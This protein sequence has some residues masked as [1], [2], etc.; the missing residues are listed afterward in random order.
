MNSIDH[1]LQSQFLGLLI[2]KDKQAG[3]IYSAFI[4][5]VGGAI[6]TFGMGAL[7]TLKQL[8][9]TILKFVTGCAVS[10][11]NLLAAI[12][13]NPSNCIQNWGWTAALNHLH[14]A[15]INLTATFSVPVVTLFASAERARE[16]FYS[17]DCIQIEL[18]KQHSQSLSA[19]KQELATKTEELK[20]KVGELS[21]L[22]TDKQSLTNTISTLT[23]S[24]EALKNPKP[25]ETPVNQLQSPQIQQEPITHDSCHMSLK[26]KD[27]EINRLKDEVKNANA[28]ASLKQ[29]SMDELARQVELLKVN[30]EDKNIAC[31][32]LQVEIN[33]LN[34]DISTL[35][36]Q[37]TQS[38]PSTNNSNPP[39]SNSQNIDSK[40]PIK[41]GTPPPP[42]PKPKNQEN[43]QK[44]AKSL[45]QNVKD[46][47]PPPPIPQKETGLSLAD[48]INAKM[49][50]LKKAND[51]PPINDQKVSLLSSLVAAL[52][53]HRSAVN[54]DQPDEA[55]SDDDWKDTVAIPPADTKGADIKAD[56][57]SN[58]LDAEEKIAEKSKIWEDA[59]LEIVST[60][61]DDVV[62]ILYQ[63][64]NKIGSKEKETDKTFFVE[65]LKVIIENNQELNA[66][67]KE[68]LIRL[69]GQLINKRPDLQCDDLSKSQFGNLFA[70]SLDQSFIDP[71][72][73]SDWP[74]DS[75]P[76]KIL[77][78]PLNFGF[79]VPQN[80]FQSQIF[81][82]SQI[83]GPVLNKSILG[84]AI[85]KVQF[86]S[87]STSQLGP[88]TF[89]IKPG[90]VA[91][92]A[93]RFQK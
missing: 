32:N 70:S 57:K 54:E 55:W 9:L 30:F 69:A 72:S 17:A 16:I 87:L 21:T 85:E 73:N 43:A 76:G 11:F 81:S 7:D 39:N 15:T 75:Y 52:E 77:E 59:L 65:T 48:Q 22:K 41:K 92:L 12:F 10:P 42:P 19:K 93:A 24:L 89:D 26:E 31:I 91:R 4:I 62:S 49:L 38:S 56:L 63:L 86:E 14:H 60:C 46:Q 50:Q 74:L 51:R 79:N 88:K 8:A 82:D 3:K 13:T 66:R 53:L 5:H 28:A 90:R 61:P 1:N 58:V 83:H 23:T 67:T 45:S 84:E 18:M 25:P 29:T 27:A 35:K 2:E 47:T 71:T 6:T 34:V 33:K 78:T 20:N 68:K 40:E 80:F 37:H 44:P 64:I 36:E